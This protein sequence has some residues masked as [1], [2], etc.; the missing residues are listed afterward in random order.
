MKFYLFFILIIFTPSTCFADEQ[1]SV[2]IDDTK[3]SQDRSYGGCRNKLCKKKSKKLRKHYL[4]SKLSSL[5]RKK[6]KGIVFLDEPS[7]KI[8]LVVKLSSRGS[9]GGKDIVGFAITNITLGTAPFTIGYKFTATLE[10]LDN[11]TVVKQS[12]ISFY[13]K[14]TISILSNTQKYKKRAAKKI[15]KFI[16]Q[17]L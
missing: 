8:M 7:D 9:S 17:F 3:V 6:Y 12:E 4:K 15:A 14:R 2:Y 16:N 10:L 13:E 5:L 1:L 11:N